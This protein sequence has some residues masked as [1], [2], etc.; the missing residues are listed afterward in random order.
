ML[1]VGLA[2]ATLAIVAYYVWFLAKRGRELWRERNAEKLLPG[3]PPSRRA[4][5]G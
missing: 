4:R 5:V 1:I 2:A 3:D